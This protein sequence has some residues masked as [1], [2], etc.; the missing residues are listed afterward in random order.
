[1]GVEVIQVYD[2]SWIYVA[3]DRDKVWASGVCVDICTIS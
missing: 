1:M 3:Q 2:V